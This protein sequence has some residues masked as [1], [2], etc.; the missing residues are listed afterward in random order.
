VV[1]IAAFRTIGSETI[2]SSFHIGVSRR[3]RM[4]NSGAGLTT[5]AFDFHPAVTAI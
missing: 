2:P 1:Y 3:R 4:E 5:I